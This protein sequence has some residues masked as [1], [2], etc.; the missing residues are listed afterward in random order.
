MWRNTSRSRPW[1]AA[2]P[3]TSWET[4]PSRVA[5]VHGNRVLDLFAAH[6]AKA[7]FFVLGWVAERHP[8]LIR[9]IVDEGHELA[10]HGYEHARADS[11]TPAQFRADVARTKTLLEDIGGVPVRGY[12]A[13]TFSIGARNPWAF[14]MLAE[15]GKTYSSR[16]NPIRNDLYGAPGAPRKPFLPAAAHDSALAEYPITTVRLAGRNWPCGGGGFFRLFP[17][18]LSRWAIGTRQ[19]RRPILPAIFY[20]HPWEVDPAQPREAGLS[21]RS[22]LRH[23]LNLDRM[24]G[25]LGRLLDDF[26]W[27]RIDRV[28]RPARARYGIACTSRSVDPI[29]VGDRRAERIGLGDSGLAGEEA[30]EHPQ[31]PQRLGV[32]A[33]AAGVVGHHLLQR[34]GLEIAGIQQHR[35]GH[36]AL[37]HRQQGAAQPRRHG[38][39]EALFG[40]V[41]Q[42]MRDQRFERLL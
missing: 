28:F 4:R 35:R 11:Q 24:E 25:R 21:A 38:Q 15:A 42:F 5:A 33:P 34:F 32:V 1:P 41:Q 14:E 3:A 18:A 27:D 2:S 16:V 12:R 7:T 20:F 23:Y 37:D 17:Y 29:V 26:A 22:R 36:G 9:R 40:A 10:S 6:N 31:T 13:A 39:G 30:F 8:A 19:R